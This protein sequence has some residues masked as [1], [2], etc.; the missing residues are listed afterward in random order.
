MSD[1]DK[2]VVQIRLDAYA[3]DSVHAT[4]EAANARADELRRYALDDETVIVGRTYTAAEL[5]EQWAQ[6]NDGQV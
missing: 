4:E 5:R 3:L 1:A 6:K 2:W